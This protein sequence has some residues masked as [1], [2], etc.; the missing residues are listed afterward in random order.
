MLVYLAAPLFSQAE[1]AF[2]QQL[3]DKLEKLGFIVFLPQRDGIEGWQEPYSRMTPEELLQAI[4]AL[5]RERV[6][7]ADIFLMVLDGR[8][9]DEGA[10]VELGLA[11]AQK[12]LLNE[13]K[14]LLGLHTDIR[15]G[16]P[17][18][19]LNAMVGGSFDCVV[20]TEE[21][22]FAALEEYR[23]ATRD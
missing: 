6:R 9:P 16:F 3:T 19:K 4:H 2:N 10:C 11:Y 23:E 8:V 12:H 1:R 13:D 22:L 5:D 15:G 7:E 20:D 21:S 14:L 18:G 17:G